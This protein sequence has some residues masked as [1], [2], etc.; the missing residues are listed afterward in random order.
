LFSPV[1][2]GAAVKSW[3]KRLLG[4]FVILL[5]ILLH[6]SKKLTSELKFMAGMQKMHALNCVQIPTSQRP[7]GK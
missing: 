1:A 2:D 6:C 4:F 3:E 5:G 7:L